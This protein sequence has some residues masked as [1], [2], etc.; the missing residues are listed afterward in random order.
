MIAP[1][2]TITSL[3]S[4]YSLAL[5]LFSISDRVR[6][7]LDATVRHFSHLVVLSTIAVATGV[8]MEGVELAH[9]TVEWRKRKRREK[10][11]LIQLEELR[12]IIPVGDGTKKS[13]KSHSE[14][15]IWAKFILRV[16]LILVV[17]GVVGEWRYGAKLDYAHEAVHQYDLEKILAADQK[18]GD[19][20]TS[21][22]EASNEAFKAKGAA[23][24]AAETVKDLTTA[25]SRLRGEAA[26]RRLSPTQ[27]ESLRKVLEKMP[28]PIAVGCNPMDNEAVDLAG[29]FVLALHSAHWESQRINW[30]PNGKYGLFISFADKEGFDTP[31]YKLLHD[32][33]IENSIPA[34]KLLVSAGD[35]S[36]SP[37]AESHVLY[38]LI[39]THPPVSAKS[40]KANDSH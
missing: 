36:F 19:A 35:K 37:P 11:N 24:A 40:Q 3:P 22:K 14:E 34:E 13:P 2:A 17:I 1:I 21:A 28:T 10:R 26:A 6:D 38:L 27:K 12:E 20:E 25:L 18:A 39:G 16:G 5:S 8:L 33:L 30:L 7:A 23:E 29:D 15:P 9:A 32:A 4:R 31:Q